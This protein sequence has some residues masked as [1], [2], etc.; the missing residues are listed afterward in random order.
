M[1]PSCESVVKREPRSSVPIAYRVLFSSYNPLFDTWAM[2]TASR[3][4]AKAFVA[5]TRFTEG[6]LN[7]AG[8]R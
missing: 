7:R 8:R 5:G 6:M 2:H 1:Y 4:V 3:L